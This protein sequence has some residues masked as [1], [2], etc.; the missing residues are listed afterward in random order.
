VTA[1]LARTGASLLDMEASHA[2]GLLS[3]RLERIRAATPADRPATPTGPKRH[4]ALLAAALG[5]RVDGPIV[6][7]DSEHEVPLD[8]SQ[9][10]RLPV[11]IAPSMPL[12]CLDLETT[13][14]ATGPGTLAFLVGIGVWL[15]GRLLVRQLL[16]PDHVDE[17]A[18]LDAIAA[19]IPAQAAL[20]TYNGRCF[21]WPLL[22]TRYRMHGRPPPSIAAHHD[23]LP[24]SRQLWRPRLGNARLATMEAAICGVR[25]G[26][27]LPGA[28]VPQRFFDYLRD[29]RPEPLRVVVEH[30]RQDIVSLAKLL[31]A[32]LGLA[33]N[34][35]DWREVH[36]SDLA[37]LARAYARRHRWAEALQVVEAGLQCAAWRR[38][39]IG[40]GPIWRRLATDR[41]RL[42]GRMGRRSD[43]AQAWLELAIRGGPGAANAWLQVA[44]HREHSLRD[45]DGA[46]AACR[47]AVAA[48]ERAR[49]WGRS[50]P[51][52]ERD[53]SHR[54]A[55]LRRRCARLAVSP[56]EP[57]RRVA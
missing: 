25:R 40:G 48:T 53:L 15:D 32:M 34:D 27:D 44:R 37:G 4:A 10:G 36:P 23:L 6:V 18:L 16:L 57:V 43:E 8:T 17:S 21:D 41:A 24:L 35:P 1:E 22:V 50:A 13:G 26:E 30:N 42:L 3:R 2:G 33:T 47:E 14:L 55:R 28:L 49:L 38:G 7:L 19:A 45:L 29:R 54:L 31:A 56:P 51:S 5:G 39:L 12:V 20:V 46:L 52:V 11:P 9:L